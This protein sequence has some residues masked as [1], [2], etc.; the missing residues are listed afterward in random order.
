M[1]LT[2]CLLGS[3]VL[4]AACG[5]N[6]PSSETAAP[7]QVEASTSPEPQAAPPALENDPMAAARRSLAAGDF[8]QAAARLFEMRA[9][10][11][12]FSPA[13]AATYREVLEEAYAAAVEAKAKGDPRAASALQLIKGATGR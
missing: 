11:K 6:E 13:E 5:S 1:K 7:Q 3:C 4:L 10:G 9:S 2:A 8:D 12:D